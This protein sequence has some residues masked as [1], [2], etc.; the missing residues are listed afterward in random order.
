MARCI[1]LLK[2]K[3]IGYPEQQK[4]KQLLVPWNNFPFM[5]SLCDLSSFFFFFPLLALRCWTCFH[6]SQWVFFH[7]M[8]QTPAG[9]NSAADRVWLTAFPC[10][11]IRSK[12][13][14][15]SANPE[16][17][18]WLQGLSWIMQS[19]QQQDVPPSPVTSGS[20]ARSRG[21]L[22]GWGCLLYPQLCAEPHH[23][24]ILCWGSQGLI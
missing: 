23:D 21:C 22:A 10:C 13:R 8:Q 6:W 5:F 12:P 14:S 9:S 17:P 7:W 18:H 1:A 3:P 24:F 15:S 11:D 4:M 20:N 2:T 16:L 19:S